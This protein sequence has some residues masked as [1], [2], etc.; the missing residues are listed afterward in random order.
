MKTDL[1]QCILIIQIFDDDHQRFIP[2]IYAFLP[3]N[4][5]DFYQKLFDQFFSSQTPRY[6]LTYE[7]KRVG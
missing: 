7:K 5:H 3:L 6:I 2:I 4:R 1:L